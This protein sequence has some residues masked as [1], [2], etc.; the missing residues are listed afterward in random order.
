[1]EKMF[2][3]PEEAIEELM[4]SMSCMSNEDCDGEHMS[5]EVMEMF[6]ED[7]MGYSCGW[8]DMESMGDQTSTTDFCMPTS[9][10]GQEMT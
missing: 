6:V 5:K 9:L 1:M 3:D 10:C 4:E 7:S 8:I 2:V